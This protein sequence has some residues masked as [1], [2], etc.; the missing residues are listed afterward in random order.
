MS[1]GSIHLLASHRSY[2]AYRYQQ[3][4]ERL[5][6]SLKHIIPSSIVMSI[7]VPNEVGK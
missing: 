2:F 6:A 3:L 1:K 5:Q 7:M 4:I